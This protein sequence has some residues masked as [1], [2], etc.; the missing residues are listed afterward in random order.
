MKILHVAIQLSKHIP[1]HFKRLETTYIYTLHHFKCTLPRSQKEYI[2][3]ITMV[4]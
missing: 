4:K 3:V 1:I 2:L